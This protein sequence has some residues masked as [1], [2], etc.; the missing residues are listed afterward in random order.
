MTTKWVLFIGTAYMDIYKDIIEGFNLLGY[1]VDYIKEL[2]SPKD[3]YNQRGYKGF[4]RLLLVKEKKYLKC[5]DDYWKKVLQESPYNKRY[6]ILFVLDG[7][8]ISPIIFSELRSRNKKIQCIN[9][10]FDTNQFVYRIDKSFKY[11]DRV[12]TFDIT[13][14]KKYNIYHLPIYWKRESAGINKNDIFAF[15]GYTFKRFCL[16]ESIHR[17]A[18]D[19]GLSSFIKIYTNPIIKRSGIKASIDRIYNVITKAEASV[20]LFLIDSEFN[21]N[22]RLS[23]LE[24]R[25]KISESRIIIDTAVEQ[26]D[27]LTARFMW[28]LGAEKKIITNNIHVKEYPFYTRN[29][30]YIIDDIEGIDEM[31]LRDFITKEFT[32]EE[33]VR[34]AI[35]LY[36]IDNWLNYMI[37][38]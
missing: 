26:Q 9:Y 22:L 29:Q 11:F 23:P 30:V 25:K 19:L 12:Y 2:S 33:T 35:R 7:Q 21:T 14:S 10:L 6:D 5:V 16:F 32:M 8:S 20:P 4:K 1:N 17:I 28:A 38:Q 3:P 31:G 18:K 34:E 36:R 13:E 27:G 24:F 15:G 37:M